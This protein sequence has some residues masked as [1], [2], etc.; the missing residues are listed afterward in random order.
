MEWAELEGWLTN[1]L[2][3]G[4]G[5]PQDKV[6]S[7]IWENTQAPATASWNNKQAL[8]IWPGPALQTPLSFIK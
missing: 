1:P 3:P 8:S 7:W 2:S 4:A 6:L 5:Q